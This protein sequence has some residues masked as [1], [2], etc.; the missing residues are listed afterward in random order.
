[1]FFESSNNVYEDIQVVDADEM[2]DKARI[3]TCIYGV[4]TEKALEV[5]EASIAMGVEAEKLSSWLGG[6]FRSVDKVILEDCLKRIEN[7]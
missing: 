4:I 2:L 3:V 1:L 6:G 5:Q 7:Y